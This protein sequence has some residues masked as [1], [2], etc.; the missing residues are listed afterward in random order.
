VGHSLTVFNTRQEFQTGDGE[1]MLDALLRNGVR[2]RYGCRRGKC[3]TCKHYVNDG[4]FDNSNASAYALLDE[5]REEGLTLLCQTYPLSDCV[6]ELR[7][8]EAG[9]AGIRPAKPKAVTGTVTGVEALAGDLWSLR[10][11][12]DGA[13]SALPGQY[14]ELTL[15]PGARGDPGEAGGGVSRTFSIAS[16][17]RDLR[18]LEV[19]VRRYPGGVFSGALDGLQP[20]AEVGVSGPYGQV[21]LRPANRPMIL[22]GDETGIGPV[23][24]VARY[25]K[26]QGWPAGITVLH[27]AP[28]EAEL[29]H[30]HELAAW[31]DGRTDFEYHPSGGLG[32]AVAAKVSGEDVDVYVFGAP[33]FCEQAVFLVEARGVSSKQIHVEQFFPAH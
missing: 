11:D 3:A 17:P 25:T 5:E 27:V 4:E 31:A 15:P 29:V 20:G 9:D 12:L 21:F 23:L 32:T 26:A 13:L 14:V 10:L 16:S 19:I 7:E 18:R 22:I 2:V 8:D 33:A 28:S 1:T 24:S 6:I 30:R